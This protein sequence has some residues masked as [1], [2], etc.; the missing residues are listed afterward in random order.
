MSHEYC[1][2]ISFVP[3]KRQ[4]IVLE[5]IR[6]FLTA[7]P[8]C[9]LILLV[10]CPLIF[11]KAIVLLTFLYYAEVYGG[12]AAGELLSAFAKLFTFCCQKWGH[13]CAMEDLLLTREAE[14]ARTKEI[15]RSLEKGV[16]TCATFAGVDENLSLEEI[17]AALQRRIRE[18]EG[19][20]PDQDEALLDAK[21]QTTTSAT[22][23]AIIEQCLPAGQLKPF[24]HN[25]FALM[26]NSGAKGSLVNH[27][28]ISCALGQQALE[29]RRVPRM[30]SGKSL[31]CFAPFDPTPRAGG[32]IS[33]RFLTGIRPQ[34]YYYH[35]M[36]GR[37]G[38]VDTAVKTSRSG[39]LQRCLIKHLE[40]LSVNYD[41][42]VRADDGS[43]VQFKYGED[44]INTQ[45]TQFLVGSDETFKF[46]Y[47]NL[48]PFC[49]KYGVGK[50]SGQLD[51]ST[52][53]DEDQ[54]KRP[55][56]LG[57][58]LA[59]ILHKQIKLM[60][61]VKSLKKL[62]A[63]CT[64][65]CRKPKRIRS[66]KNKEVLD[67]HFH[68]THRPATVIK[69]HKSSKSSGS[70]PKVDVVFEEDSTVVKKIPLWIPQRVVAAG[71][72]GNCK[73]VIRRFTSGETKGVEARIPLVLLRTPEPVIH[74]LGT[75][76]HLGAIG[77]ALE[78]KLEDYISRNPHHLLKTEDDAYSLKQL[79]W[80]KHL[81]SMAPP[82][83]AVGAL[84]AQSIGE[85]STQMTL[86]T[87][88]LA[89]HGGANVTLGIP[90]LRELLMTASQAIKTPSMTLPL[91]EGAGRKV[92]DK[93]KSKLYC[94]KLGELLQSNG[95]ITVRESLV[96]RSDRDLEGQEA[97]NAV[98]R[99]DDKGQWFRRYTIRFN[100]EQLSL[101]RS[102]F[103]LRL[104]EVASS[105]GFK[106]A[107]KLLQQVKRE[108]RRAGAR[109]QISKPV[110][111]ENSDKDVGGEKDDEE[112]AADQNADK[113]SSDEEEEEE[114]EG[115]K[116]EMEGY[117]DSS[118]EEEEED[119]G[120]SS[121]EEDAS[122]S[123]DESK[124]VEDA[125]STPVVIVDDESQVNTNES[126][127]PKK[128]QKKSK[129]TVKQ[130]KKSK[131]RVVAGAQEESFLVAVASTVSKSECWV[132]CRRSGTKNDDAAWVECT[133]QFPASMKRL[134][135]LDLAESVAKDTIVRAIKGIESS[136]VIDNKDGLA[137]QTNGCNL[138]AAWEE[139]EHVDVNRI[140]SNDVGQILHNYGVE[141]ARAAIIREI[142]SVFGVYG[143]GVDPRHMTLLAD[144]MTFEGGYRPFNRVGIE[145]TASPLLRMTFESSNTF[146]TGSALYSENDP[147]VT[148]S[149]R[150]ALGQLMRAGSGAVDL[151]VPTATS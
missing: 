68:P 63:G 85:P 104:P 57:L 150:I 38:L 1:L 134:L 8:W 95:G 87:F 107:Q 84:A 112:L 20:D 117:E 142:K 64:V 100:L 144:Q 66:F 72:V 14:A 24:P 6:L 99:A 73:G 108:L 78:N 36:A 51:L 130:K 33:D 15:A 21:M 42:T 149:A 133:L 89:G 145:G 127:T 13:T 25:C 113:E 59:P 28:Q 132:G 56:R 94:V 11:E 67:N 74:Q 125:E 115:A 12:N 109:V 47:E 90:R 31:P 40:S 110:S 39:Y 69:V 129:L 93:I 81:K 49:S 53:T 126:M 18:S 102:E 136:F 131:S 140:S 106:F 43:I 119:D 34:E 111:T 146:L 10:H 32:Y 118:E 138:K 77:E 80:L 83:E 116:K 70:P 60:K 58:K 75:D 120:G 79:L 105:I 44:S 30:I 128:K 3:P 147:L 22:T 122:D 96:R 92:A 19:G 141:A 4:P 71:T 103:G 151:L 50:G 76:L 143:I 2:S 9:R 65:Y 41:G 121:G 5:S 27:S 86:N 48:I 7:S 137:V 148:P 61:Q 55:L 35:C 54:E 37:E 46:L 123:E 124:E 97:A 29:G 135:M 114:D 52:E 98:R 45:E 26:V 16:G 62:K 17:A 101:I 91:R 82:G 88:H 23:S 139:A